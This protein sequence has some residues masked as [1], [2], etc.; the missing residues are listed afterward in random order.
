MKQVNTT[1]I[2]HKWELWGHKYLFPNAKLMPYNNESFDLL[3]GDSRIDVKA[4]KLFTKKKGRYFDFLI[5]HN[6]GCDY[7][8]LIGYRYRQDKSPQKIWLI[9]ASLINDR[10]RV[11]IGQNHNGQWKDFEI[12]L[13]A[14]A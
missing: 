8:L 4:S 6:T 9:P 5:K 13:K 10:R 3:D 1:R 12:P 7:F 2:G 14:V 11:I